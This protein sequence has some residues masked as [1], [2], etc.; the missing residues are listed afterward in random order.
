MI[1]PTTHIRHVTRP[2]MPFAD[3]PKTSMNDKHHHLKHELRVPGDAGTEICRQPERLVEGIG[4]QGLS[5]SHDCCHGLHRRADHIVVRVLLWRER[6]M[7]KRRPQDEKGG[8]QC[9]SRVQQ[10]AAEY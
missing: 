6:E 2:N 4:V 9:H 7:V 5:S 3:W 1:T 10:V 8:K